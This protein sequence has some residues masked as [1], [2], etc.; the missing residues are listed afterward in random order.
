VRRTAASRDYITLPPRTIPRIAQRTHVPPFRLER[1]VAPRVRAVE[2]IRIAQRGRIAV[3]RGA[4]EREA[5][6][7]G[8]ERCR[9]GAERGVRG[10]REHFHGSLRCGSIELSARATIPAAR[11]RGNECE[12]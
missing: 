9:G 11:E 12:Q 5:C 10:V 1:V 7:R 4:R 3:E 6:G 8:V 2:A